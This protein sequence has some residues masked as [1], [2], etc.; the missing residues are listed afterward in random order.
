ML[1]REL[2]EQSGRT[3][4]LAFG[5]LNPP[6]TGH[7]KLIEKLKSI[8]GDHFLFLS[9]SQKPKTDPLDFNTKLKFAQSFFPDIKIGHP[10]VNTPVAALQ[11]L[12]SK[13]YTDV[14]FVAGSDRVEG[15]QKL[16]D[17]Y[18][19]QPDKSGTVPF[20]FNSIR[21]I[22]AG[23]RDPDADDVSGMSA[24]KM[25]AA[26]VA[27]DI[28]SFSQGVPNPKLAQQMYDAVRSA[29]GVKENF[30]NEN[31][32]GKQPDS[33]NYLLQLER[34]KRANM[35]ILHILDKGTGKRTEV[36]GKMGYETNGYDPQDKL[37]QLLDKV[38]KS[39]SVSDLMNGEVVSIN[40]RHPDGASAKAA[41]DKAYNENFADGKKPGRK[42]LAKRSGVNTTEVLNTQATNAKWTMSTEDMS[43]LEFTASNGIEYQIDFLAPFIGPDEIHPD[44]FIPDISRE[45]ED[46]AVFVEFSQKNATGAA[47]Q[48]VAGTGAAA[49]VFGIVTNTILEFAKKRKPSMIYFQAAEVNRRK[50]YAAIANRLVKSM[51]GYTV[52]QMGDK[53]A[54]YSNALV[55]PATN[56]NF[57][58]NKIKYSAPNFEYEW[59][60]ALR[61]PEFRKIGKDAWIE[62]AGKGKAVTIKSAKGINNTDAAD[63]DSFKSL[64]KDKQARALAQLKSGDVEMPIVAV[65][66][67]GWKE[68]IGG[69]TR[70]T[71]MLA[72]D[73]KATVWVFKVPN[74][75]AELAENFADGKN[76]GRKGLAKRSGVNTK[77]SVSSLRKT[78]KKSSGEKQRMAHWLAN[79][80]AGRA[81]KK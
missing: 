41:A 43:R 65:Y 52:K 19:G 8:P 79:M 7:A 80:K 2:F 81:K 77:A 44:D 29:M 58:E 30:A 47:K 60:E 42:G 46:S 18:N 17:T 9:H 70:L 34:D 68:L 27:G 72:Q 57:A 55:N 50:L 22:S 49:E 35:L 37:H 11:H 64:D 1:L 31:I 15:F 45:A 53:F 12:Q 38:G 3:A 62:L 24:S 13:G 51:S 36:R 54:V 6:T 5:R 20:E 16:F 71:A 32:I 4:V 59:E 56:E 25:R 39:A 14:I 69:N 66:P 75:V 63:A 76:P 40:P 28:E 61:Y 21:V 10:E 33:K 74:E 73:G 48:G 26:A 78:A 23:E 67:D